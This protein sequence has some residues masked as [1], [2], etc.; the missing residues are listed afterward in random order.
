MNSYD[1]GL[2]GGFGN[3]FGGMFT[4]SFIMPRRR[5]PRREVDLGEDS[6]PEPAEQIKA[7]KPRERD[8]TRP[9]EL[10]I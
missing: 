9:P 6:H 4:G 1:I 8:T 5:W 7:V 2:Q 10:D 3:S